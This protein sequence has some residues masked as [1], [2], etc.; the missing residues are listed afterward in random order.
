MG[1]KS[2]LHLSVASAGCWISL[3]FLGEIWS[4]WWVHPCT[5]DKRSGDHNPKEMVLNGGDQSFGP[6][7]EKKSEEVVTICA[8]CVA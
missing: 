8:D 1:Y 3:S 7:L 2:N 6:C 5:L 4:A